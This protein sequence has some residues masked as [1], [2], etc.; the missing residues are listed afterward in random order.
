MGGALTPAIQRLIAAK[1]FPSVSPIKDLWALSV[2][3]ERE[4]E[5]Q[6]FSFGIPAL[7]PITVIAEAEGLTTASQVVKA[8][9][10]GE[11]HRVEMK[12]VGECSITGVVASKQG[13]AVNAHVSLYPR[14]DE[15]NIS[16]IY[17]E[18]TTDE[19]EA[20]DLRKIPVGKYCSISRH[21]VLDSPL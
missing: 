11:E 6:S 2:N 12:L 21:L 13:A 7:G 15:T 5:G 16:S 3:G 8:L 18:G 1:C 14:D 20:F 9:T 10:I 17:T 19:T 4:R